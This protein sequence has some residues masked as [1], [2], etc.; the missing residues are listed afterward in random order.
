MQGVVGIDVE[1]FM[2]LIRSA[3]CMVV[4]QLYQ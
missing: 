2:A 3:H 4:T 1:D